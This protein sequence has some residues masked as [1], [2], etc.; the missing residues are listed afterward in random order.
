M[1]P[2]GEVHPQKGELRIG[3]GIDETTHQVM[4]FRNYVVVLTAER[5]DAGFRFLARQPADPIAM[6]IPRS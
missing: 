3:N 4:L 6:Q 2:A 5:H 1:D